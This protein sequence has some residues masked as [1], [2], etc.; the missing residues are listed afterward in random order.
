MD[1]ICLSFPWFVIV[2]WLVFLYCL[3]MILYTYV[4]III[5]PGVLDYVYG[6]VIVFRTLQEFMRWLQKQRQW[7]KPIGLSQKPACRQPVNYIHHSIVAIL[8]LLLSQK[9]NIHF[10]IPQ[11]VEGWVHVGGWPHT[12]TLYGFIPVRKQSPIQVVTCRL[13]VNWLHW[14]KPMC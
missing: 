11:R 10:T 13:S 6:A 8:L 4:M 5:K 2:E 9:T 7:T 14:T 1:H 12:Q 3:F